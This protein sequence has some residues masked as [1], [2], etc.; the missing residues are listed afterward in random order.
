MNEGVE[1]IA[2]D[3]IDWMAECHKWERECHK[4]TARLDAIESDG[5]MASRM[6]DAVVRRVVEVRAEMLD[7]IRANDI[8]QYDSDIRVMRGLIDELLDLLVEFSRPFEEKAG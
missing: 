2:P 1:Q 5:R 7:A 6:R 8:N 3:G 4:L